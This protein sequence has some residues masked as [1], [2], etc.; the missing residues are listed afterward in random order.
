MTKLFDLFLIAIPL[1][2]VA[3]IV[4]FYVSFTVPAI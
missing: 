1:V 2:V 4:W 3:A